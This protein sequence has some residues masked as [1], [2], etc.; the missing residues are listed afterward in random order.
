MLVVDGWRLKMKRPVQDIADRHQHDA[1]DKR[2]LARPWALPLLESLLRREMFE[3]QSSEMSDWYMNLMEEVEQE[4]KRPF[5]DFEVGTCDNDAQ[6]AALR[7]FAC[8]RKPF[9]VIGL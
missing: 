1:D 2:A 7:I 3:A 6:I 8:L 9:E 4:F 5:Q